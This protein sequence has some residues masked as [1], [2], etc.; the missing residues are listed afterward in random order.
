MT[1]RTLKTSQKF[2]AAEL[3]LGLEKAVPN[4]RQILHKSNY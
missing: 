1:Q 3:G 4:K 2:K